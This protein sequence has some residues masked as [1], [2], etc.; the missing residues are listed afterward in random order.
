[1]RTELSEMERQALELP[2]GVGIPLSPEAV[3]R[4]LASPDYHP[5]LGDPGTARHYRRGLPD[6]TGLH[7]VVTETGAE[8]HRDLFDPHAGPGAILLHLATDSPRQALALLEAGW[9]VLRRIGR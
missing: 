8:L 2:T 7:L 9:S 6:G 4:L 5:S 3:D 1:M